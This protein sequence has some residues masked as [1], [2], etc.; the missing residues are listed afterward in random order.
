MTEQNNMNNQNEENVNNEVNETVETP[1][2]VE[3]EVPG[4]EE[5]EV[6][7]KKN[8][9]REILDWIVSIAVAFVIVAVLHLYIFVNVA[10]D[11]RSMNST[12][13]DGER[14]IV[15]RFMYEPKNSDIVVIAPT[16]KEGSIKGK[17]ILS[18]NSRQKPLYV[19]RVIAVEGQTVDVKGGLVF[20][21]GVAIDEP[22]L[23]EGMTTT[24]YG[25]STEFPLTVPENCVIVM[26]DN[27][28]NST[29]SRDASVGI[30]REEQI[31]GKAVLRIWPLN[32]F[33]GLK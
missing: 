6:K 19:K 29:D 11:G 12:L 21:D 9:F 22:Y 15:S 17:S 26:G 24:L 1:E 28:E 2:V 8:I 10:V 7:K 18:Y 5:T 14:L 30:V 16:L 25:K 3:I 32:K 27:R 4:Y 31:V 13:Q 23:D 33:G 20:V